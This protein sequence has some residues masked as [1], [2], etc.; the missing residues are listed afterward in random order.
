MNA[1]RTLLALAL[2]IAAG[3]ASAALAAD[4]AAPSIASEVGL[5]IIFP[6]ASTRVPVHV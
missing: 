1:R 5:L 3:F 2:A 6:S 4:A